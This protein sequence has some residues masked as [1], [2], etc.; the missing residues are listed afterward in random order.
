[1]MG[2]LGESALAAGSLATTA[3]LTLLLFGLG[4]VS[5]VAALGAQA[6]G[7]GDASGLRRAVHQGLW[8]SLAVG[9]P[10]AVLLWHVGPALIALGQD[11]HNVA[12]AAAYLHA[13]IWGMVPALWLVVLRCFVSVA[14]DPGLILHVT[15]AGVVVNA[16]ADYALMFGHWGMPA[17]GLVGAGIASSL[18]NAAMA[19]ALLILICRK[20][21][22]RRFRIARTDLRPDR[23]ILRDL[24]AIGLPIGATAFLEFGLFAAAA[25]LMGILGTTQLAAHQIAVQCIFVSYMIPLGISHA[26]TVRVGRGAG[27]ASPGAVA[28]AGWS[29]IAIAAGVMI[30]PA[31]VFLLIPETLA[32]L[33][34]D[35]RAAENLPLIAQA[36][37][38]LPIAALFQLFDGCQVVAAGAL[39]GLKDTRFA[40]IVSALGYWAVG[41]P[42]SVLLAFPLGLGGEGVWLGLAAG[43]MIVAAALVWRFN[44]FRNWYCITVPPDTRPSSR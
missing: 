31:L 32:G 1:M 10:F 25:L 44:R 19:A 43:L 16:L 9:V 22:L 4:V 41:V 24:F 23:A 2:W 7:A 42:V 12:L 3:Y 39:R 14:D 28:Q 37:A 34:V 21:R 6:L 26:A 11:P 36:A 29:A 27:A 8:A 35:A 33:F 38:L 5:A 17:L 15:S 30:V 18:V 13:A 20:R 40:M